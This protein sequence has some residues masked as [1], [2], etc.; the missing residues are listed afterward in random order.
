MTLRHTLLPAITSLLLLLSPLAHAVTLKI[1]TLAPDGSQWMKEMRASA[2]LIDQQTQGRVKLRFYP[3]GVMG[4]DRSVLRKIRVG[5]LHGGVLTSGSLSTIYP[6]IQIYTLPFLFS[7]M[8]QADKIRTSMDPVLLA[9]L[10]QKGWISFGF[11]EGGFA[12]F[13]SLHPLN[14]VDQL[15]QQKVWS[16]EGDLISRTAL[17]AID[18]SPIPLPLT[19]VLTGLQTGLIDTV[20]TS[21]I[22]A[23]ALQWHTQVKHLADVPLIYLYATLA[24]KER[25]LNKLSRE[26]RLTLDKILT[27]AVNRINRQNRQDH[28]KAMAALK[29]QGVIFD[30]PDPSQ[31]Q[32]WK[33]QVKQAVSDL[34]D[35]DLISKKLY[36]DLNRQLEEMR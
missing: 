9:G 31:L 3:G 36:Q 27:E 2:K 29:K 35:G 10:K 14:D 17:E 6:D 25:S 11:M 24:I 7:S 18:I 26:D 1:A 4:N 20:A 5:Q 15:R 23:I 19:D 28:T 16:P 32:R 13:M 22:G 30:H 21:P 33:N 34:I 12:Y 8:E